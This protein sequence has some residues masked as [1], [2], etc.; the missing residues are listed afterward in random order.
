M[1]RLRQPKTCCSPISSHPFDSVDSLQLINTQIM[2][3]AVIC[4]LFLSNELNVI[5]G[6]KDPHGVPMGIRKIG[7]DTGEVFVTE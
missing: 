5:T 1:K 4:I 2:H 6:H 3:L 7:C